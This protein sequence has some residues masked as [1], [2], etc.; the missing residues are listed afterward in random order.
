MLGPG[1]IEKI[2]YAIFYS[3]TIRPNAEITLE[4]NPGTIME[5]DFRRYRTIGITRTNIGIQSFS[6]E[7]LTFLGRCHTCRGAIQTLRGARE[8][9]FESVGFDLIYGLP[10]Q[11]HE[12]LEKD[13]ATAVSFHP[14]H[15]SCYML[16]YEPGTPLERQKRSGRIEPLADSLLADFFLT[17]SDFFRKSEYE[18]Y[19]ISNFARTPALRS[20]HNQKYWRHAPYMGFGPAAHS[21]RG[22][23]RSWNIK[24]VYEYIRRTESTQPVIAGKETL[25]QEQLMMETL[26][27][28]LR[29]SD[30]VSLHE[31]EKK[32]QIK[33]THLFSSLIEDLSR[34]G[35]LAIDDHRMMLSRKGMLFHDYISS[36]FSEMI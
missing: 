7:N 32:Y 14:D 16:T 13:L 22:S 4:I 15:V 29:T 25:T 10:G 28:G 18:H 19:E 12:D 11:S 24:D 30:G 35:L 5:E 36:R 17:T 21:F 27:L 23:T 2:L 1:A 6:D 26:F 31:F 8:Q 3:F 20:R 33:P 34:D 9:D